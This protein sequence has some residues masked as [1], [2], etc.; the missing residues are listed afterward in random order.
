MTRTPFVPD[1]FWFGGDYNPEQW[2]REVWAQDVEL[3][4]RAGVNTATDRRLLLGAAGAR[5]GPL[6]PRLARRRHRDAARRRHRRRAGHPDRLPAALVH[7]GPPGRA[8]RAR[9]RHAAVARQPRHLLR[10]RARLPRGVPLDRRRPRPAVRRPPGAAGVARA[11]RVR[12]VLLVRPR[13]RRVPARGCRRGTGRSTRSTRP[14]GPRSGASTTSRGTR[15]CRPARPSTCTTRRR[16]STSGASSPTRCS[17]RCASRRAEIRA[18]GLVGPDHDELHAPHV[19]PPR[20]VELVRRARRAVGRPLPR[21]HRPRRG[22]ARR[23]RRPTSRASWADGGPWLLMEQ[24]MSSISTDGPDRLQGPG[25]RGAQLARLRRPR[26]AVVAVLPVAR[27]RRRARR[28]GTARWCRTPA[29]TPRRSGPCAS[30]ARCSTRIAEVRPARPP[31][32]G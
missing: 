32:A 21:H 23:L 25:A 19:E 29:P 3:M 27:L 16:P 11:Q 24:S 13:R 20:A 30:W 14:G 6:R 22:G 10:L 2:P 18:A 9:R 12:H 28:P 31:T 4:Q 17:T 26:G 8:A 15:C 5:G 1:R 7:R